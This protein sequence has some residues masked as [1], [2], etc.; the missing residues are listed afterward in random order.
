[1][2]VA[3]LEPG[4]LEM[5]PGALWALEMEHGV[6]GILTE[7]QLEP[8]VQEMEPGALWALEMEHGVLGILTEP[9]LEPGI[10]EMAPLEHGVQEMEPGEPG[11]QEME[12]LELS[13]IH[14]DLAVEPPENLRILT[15]KPD[16]PM[17]VKKFCI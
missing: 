12:P 8:G 17:H 10:L 11:V 15:Q 9:Q 3:Q 5:E 7:P 6:L 14:G 1:M 2:A 13:G 16:L 4:I